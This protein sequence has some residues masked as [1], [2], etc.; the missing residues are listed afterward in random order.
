[1][2]AK[3]VLLKDVF[4]EYMIPH[5]K[6]HMEKGG[7]IMGA[8]IIEL[9]Y[10]RSIEEVDILA[11]GTDK[12]Y[13]SPIYHSVIDAINMFYDIDKNTYDGIAVIASHQPCLMCTF[14]LSLVP[15]LREVYYL[16]DYNET[17]NMFNITYPKDDWIR[18]V[19]KQI[20]YIEYEISHDNF[21]SIK[22]RKLELEPL[23]KAQL[24]VEYLTM[25]KNSPYLGG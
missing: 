2:L 23:V 18:N 8:A 6:E 11:V 16:F 22:F 7:H 15:R 19:K 5:T 17:Y 10:K 13:I 12:K 24:S 25:L 1:M 21:K 14:A 4:F 20:Q 9:Q 3:D